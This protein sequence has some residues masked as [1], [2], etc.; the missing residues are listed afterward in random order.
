VRVRGR[1]M[2][3]EVRCNTLGT[4]W[5]LGATRIDVRVDGRQ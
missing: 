3:M 4:V 5:Q 1:Q 2:S